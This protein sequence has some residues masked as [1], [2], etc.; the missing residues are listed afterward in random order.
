LPSSAVDSVFSF[1]L[2]KITTVSY[3]ENPRI[4]RIAITVGGDTSRPVNA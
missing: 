3:S 1:T 2:S 4:V